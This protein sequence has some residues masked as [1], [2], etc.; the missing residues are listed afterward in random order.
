MESISSLWTHPLEHGHLTRSHTLK[1][2]QSSFYQQPAN[3]SSS[4]AVS[5]GSWAPPLSRLEC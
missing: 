3:V 2:N 4:S 1:E 5:E